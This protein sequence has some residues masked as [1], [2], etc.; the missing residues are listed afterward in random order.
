MARAGWDSGDTQWGLE[1]AEAAIDALGASPDTREYADLLHETA[2]AYVMSGLNEKA[3]PV[4]EKALAMAQSTGDVR[5]QAEVLATQGLLASGTE[6]DLNAAQAALEEAI[7]LSQA[8]NL[9]L[10]ESR[11]RNNLAHIVGSIRGDPLQARELMRQATELAHLG[12][13]VGMQLFDGSHG[14][15]FGIWLGDLIGVEHELDQLD[16]LV[17]GSID[18][19]IGA[20]D[21]RKMRL[22]LGVARGHTQE[23]VAGLQ[24][25]L[26]EL[27]ETRNLYSYWQVCNYLA[28]A[29]IERSELQ[30]AELA[31]QEA[32]DAAILDFTSESQSRSWKS[33]AHAMRGEIELAREM[34]QQ[35][36]ESSAIAVA[37]LDAV[38]ILRS[39]AHLAIAEARW[40]DA[41][42]A[43]E[44]ATSRLSEMGMRLFRARDLRAWAKGH[45]SRGE[46]EDIERAREL[47]GEARVEFEDMGSDGYVARIDAQLQELR[48]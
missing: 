25:L 21:L 1:L 29:L 7:A 44:A 26:E 9:P 11:A 19:G 43:F 24:L 15:I 41:W 20:S 17:E 8:H 12:G 23:T 40:S 36:R 22:V 13:D 38:G 5:I 39:E 33:I 45:I 10:Q 37:A 34:L 32:I 2:R 6:K 4:L 30:R 35:A 18:P 48:G 31:A 28:E 27:R 46:P 3:I 42:G 14:A 47:L 16:E